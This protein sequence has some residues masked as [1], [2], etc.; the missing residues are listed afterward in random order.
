MAG[1]N[2]QPGR[3][4]IDK[5]VAVLE[6]FQQG[7]RELSL[8]QLAA[9]TGLPLST[10]YRIANE[11]AASSFLERAEGG[12]YR[13]GL[14]TWEV[15]TRADL[16]TSMLQVVVPFMQDLYE[17]T[18]ENV[19]LAILSRHE[20]L[21]IEKIYGARSAASRTVRGGRL[22]LHCTGVGKVLLAAAPQ[23][24]VD[25]LVQR[26]LRSYTPHTATTGGQ[27]ARALSEVR[28]TGIAYQRDELDLGLMSVAA[29]VADAT[30]DVVAALGVVLRSS[31]Y[32]LQQLAPAV[33]T[34]AASASREM[35]EHG[36]RGASAERMSE[37]LTRADPARKRAGI[38]YAA[39]ARAEG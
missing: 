6:A 37:M 18:H 30:G 34:A 24:L 15:G 38:G 3:S 14:R 21:F 20:A 28:R 17:A 5:A 32:R 12:G 2:K 7:P 35:R 29:P 33:R 25:E 10:A 31:R 27:L 26:G 36:V 9:R 13:V 23:E 11:L 1:R 16:A 8:N 19:Q 22:P 39:T 4:V